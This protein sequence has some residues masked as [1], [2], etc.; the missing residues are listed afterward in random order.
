MHGD[1][2]VQV[3]DP[4]LEETIVGTATVDRTWPVLACHCLTTG[5]GQGACP[6]ADIHYCCGGVG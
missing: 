6:L 5:F 3:S 4:G 2:P 1:V